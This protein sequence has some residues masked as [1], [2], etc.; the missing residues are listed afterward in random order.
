MQEKAE[1]G[2]RAFA[3]LR[4]RDAA[5]LWL[6]GF[7]VSVMRWLEL[8][9]FSLFALEQ[10][11]SPFLVA[12]T[13][14]ARMAPLLLVT[15]FVTTLAEGSDRRRTLATA[16]GAMAALF[17]LLL[18]LELVQGVGFGLVLLAALAG[19]VFWSLE[20]PLRRTMLA[21]IGG[22]ARVGASMG[23][24]I[25]S[26][27]S[28]RVLGALLGGV[29]VAWLGLAGVFAIG[30]LLYGLGTVLVLAA[31]PSA[32]PRL[33]PASI[34][35]LLAALTDG[36]RAVRGN[37]LLEATIAVSAAFNLWGFPYLA[38]APVI[39][40]RVHG[41]SADG[42]GLLMAAEPLAATLAALAFAAFVPD[43][44][45]RVVYAAGPVLFVTGTGL[46]ALASGLIAACAALMLAGIGMA[47]FATAQMVLPMRAAPA[48]MRVRVL[49][50]V[51]TSIGVAPLGLAH[52]GLLA[53]W[54][55]AP[56][57]LGVISLEGLLAMTL[58]LWRWPDLLVL[59]PP[60]AARAAR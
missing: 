28:T 45:F 9:A 3:V 31:R 6:A 27:Q 7:A 19:G 22:L 53:E 32:P 54:L 13:V 51:A 17:A 21:E 25:T 46:F 11:G 49:G 58:I 42:T 15:P 24:E 47:G 41:L 56:V 48:E 4:H 38:L 12:L 43:R 55:G 20:F 35:Q 10:T 52:A 60:E 59:A 5:R 8:L 40:E 16:F 14:V 30:L 26:N 33:A 2:L 36:V 29:S 57:A 1:K 44:L 39:A 37:G 18:V 50:L 34:R 23:L